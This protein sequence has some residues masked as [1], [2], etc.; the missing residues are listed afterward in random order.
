MKILQLLL[1]GAVAALADLPQPPP[2]EGWGPVQGKF[3]VGESRGNQALTGVVPGSLPDKVKQ[4]WSFKAGDEIKGSPVV[5]GNTVVVGGMD[6]VVYALSTEGKLL[7]KFETGNGIEAAA[8]ILNN[9]VYISNLTGVLYALDLGSGKEKWKYATEGQISGAANWWKTGS[10]LRI[11]V[12]SYDYYLHCVDAATGKSIWKYESDNFINGA[13]A[14][15]D[16]TA[17]FGGCDGYLHAVDIATGSAAFKINVATYVPGSAPSSGAIAGDRVVTGSRDKHVYCFS[18]SDGKLLWRYNAGE[19]VDASPLI[20]G[21]RV[22]VANMRGDLLLLKLNDGSPVWTYET[23][24]PLF[25]NP[26]TGGGRIYTAGQDGTIRC[27][28]K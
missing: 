8:L 13:A 11:L 18:R 5:A 21:D 9:T 3:P 23:G 20:I 14:C 28:G 16:G 22:L 4:L 15:V 25:G 12:G 7:W 26:A 1:L 17:L 2:Y 10:S 6:G 24:T 27:L 19:K